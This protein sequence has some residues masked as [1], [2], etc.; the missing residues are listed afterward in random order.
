MISK[1][2]LRL[3]F[4]DAGPY[5]SLYGPI[6]LNLI[7]HANRY[8]ACKSIIRHANVGGPPDLRAVAHL[9]IIIL[10]CGP[11]DL[12]AVAHQWAMAHRL[13]T[14]GLA[15]IMYVFTVI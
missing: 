4:T 13:R 1:R 2:S 14:A 10:S 7:W 8:S 9:G 15:S 12:H 5:G 3:H 6:F 11:P